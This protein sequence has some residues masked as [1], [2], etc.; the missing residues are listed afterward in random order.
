MEVNIK[1]DLDC[2]ELNHIG[3]SAE[4]RRLVTTLLEAGAEST[5][6]TVKDIEL[7]G[8]GSEYEEEE[9]REY[10]EEFTEQGLDSGHKEVHTI[11]FQD[12]KAVVKFFSE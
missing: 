2:E 7:L 6:F 4:L 12:F 8:Y 3:I 5:G 1:F 10:F 9:L 11:S